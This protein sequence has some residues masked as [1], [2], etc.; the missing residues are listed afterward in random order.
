MSL[1]IYVSISGMGLDELAP[2]G[3]IVAHQHG[4]DPVGFSAVFDR[5]LA[6]DTFER[7]HGSFPQLFG[8][9]FSKTFITL[10][11]DIFLT[12]GR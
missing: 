5:D 1:S 2:W 11:M 9:H 4:E 6:Q 8:V 12:T 3:D 7:V 10:G